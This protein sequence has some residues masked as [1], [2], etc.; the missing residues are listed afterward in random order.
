[1]S[2]IISLRACL[3]FCPYS[4][5]FLAVNVFKVILHLSYITA[6]R[7]LA[8]LFALFLSFFKAFAIFSYT[9]FS[10]SMVLEILVSLFSLEVMRLVLR[11]DLLCLSIHSYSLPCTFPS[12]PAILTLY[13]SRSAS[14]RFLVSDNESSKSLSS[15]DELGLLKGSGVVALGFSYSMILSVTDC[16]VNLS[17]CC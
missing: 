13:D 12:K 10:V 3:I 9:C 17:N 2:V 15:W 7:F 4:L 14:A 16:L 5:F 6:M 1:M 11:S 8:T